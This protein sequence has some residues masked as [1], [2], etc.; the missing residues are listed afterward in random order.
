MRADAHI[1]L[2]GG[3]FRAIP[4]RSVGF[5]SSLPPSSDYIP[6]HRNAEA[7]SPIPHSP[8]HPLLP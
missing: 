3:Q 4:C 7:V 5:P 2:A 6:I 1:D 8:L